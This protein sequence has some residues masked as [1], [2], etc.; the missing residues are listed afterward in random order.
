MSR[1]DRANPN[2]RNFGLRSR[3]MASA[4]QNAL[5]ESMQSQSSISAMSD[6]F[7]QFVGYMKSEHSISD[8]RNIE[9]THVQQYADTLRERTE[10]GTLSPATAQ[11]YLSAVNRTLEIA[12]GDRAVHVAPVREAGLPERSGIATTSRAIS[13]E[14]HQAAQAGVSDRLGAQMDLQREL[15]LRFEESCKIDAARALS[16]AERTGSV[17]ISDGTKGGRNRDVPIVRSEQIDALRAAAAI[18]NGDRSMIPSH[19]SY[20]QYRDQCYQQRPN[21]LNFHGERHAYAQQ[22]YEALTGV[23]CPVAAG[24]EHGRAHYQHIAEERSVSVSAAREI[25]RSAREQV[26]AELGHGRIDVTNSYLG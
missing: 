22:R 23:K 10:T 1:S 2:S 19:Q 8:M 25:D 16:Q 26:A 3:D 11:N 24:V 15:G 9:K 20:A 7:N 14:Q 4:G 13:P 17:R 21:G 12:R 5:R 18:Q 6:R